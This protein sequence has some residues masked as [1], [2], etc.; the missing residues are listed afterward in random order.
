MVTAQQSRVV[1]HVGS[2]KSGTTFLQQAMWHHR[3]ALAEAGI[4]LPGRRQREMF[5]AAIEVREEHEFWG[6]APDQIDGTWARL[7]AQAREHRGTTV[8]SHEL[9][10]A[11]TPEQIERALSHLEGVELHLVLTA[12]DLVRQVTS[13]WQERV[14][15]GGTRSFRKFSRRI[16]GQLERGEVD[17]GF[18]GHQN[19]AGILRRW[20]GHLPPE[21]VHVVVAPQPGA[22]PDVLWQR[23]GAAVGFDAS[24][25]D[26]QVVSRTNPALGAAQVAVLRHVNA[27]L[28]RRIPQPGYARIVKDQF[29]ETLLAGQGGAR[30]QCPPRLAR[31]LRDQAR[32]WNQ[33]MRGLG[34]ATHGML[35]ELIPRIS[36]DVVAPDRVPTEEVLDAFAQ[37][38]AS[39]LIERAEA[40]RAS[41]S[42]VEV[43]SAWQRI[44]GRLTR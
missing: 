44:R 21:R 8:M 1:L 30:P 16:M 9:L 34:Y 2:P 26:P 25:L 36:E 24:A 28:A 42:P 10:S 23:F 40:G 7:C 29:A 3:P 38:V 11:A 32:L 12:R 35:S 19:P 13:E 22:G 4:A 27:A 15:N 39:L 6:Y 43:T 18:W 33:E 5:L 31:Q 41:T 17:A 37:A 14:K 20:G